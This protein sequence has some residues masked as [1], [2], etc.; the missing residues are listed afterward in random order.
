MSTATITL[1]LCTLQASSPNVIA[2]RYLDQ[3]LAAN[4]ALEANDLPRAKQLFERALELRPENPTCA[5]DLA[6]VA[7]RSGDAKSSLDWLARAAQWGYCDASVALW[8][9]DLA[10]L[11]VRSRFEELVKAM[12]EH[13]AATSARVPHFL[14]PSNI[15]RW[16]MSGMSGADATI[17]SVHAP[18][19][20]RGPIYFEE[21]DLDR[22]TASSHVSLPIETPWCLARGSDGFVRVFS[23]QHGAL[24]I[25]RPSQREV[26]ME[27]ELPDEMCEL[28]SLDVAP[29]GA[30]AVFV[31]GSARRTL[32]DVGRRAVVAEL[33][34][35]PSCRWGT[36][37]W[38]EDGSS[39]AC[40]DLHDTVH[41]Y[42]NATGVEACPP[43]T[44]REICS[45]A[46]DREAKHIAVG[47]IGGQAFVFDTATGAKVS[48]LQI[49][50]VF[51]DGDPVHSIEFSSDCTKVVAAVTGAGSIGCW[52]VERGTM[53]WQAEPTGGTE[54]RFVAHF[55]P[56][57]TR[58]LAAGMAMP[59][60]RVLDASDGRTLVD[61]SEAQLIA[62][63]STPDARFAFGGSSG[64][65]R[66]HGT[67]NFERRATFVA[68]EPSEWLYF[69]D[70]LY[71][72]GT[73]DA[74]ARELV[75]SN[76]SL[77]SVSRYAAQ[78]VDPKRV[79]ASIAGVHVRTARLA[80][81][82]KLSLIGNS[83]VHVAASARTVDLDVEVADALGFA[84]CEAEL[85]GRTLDRELSKVFV[86]LDAAPSA[87]RVHLAIARI[88]GTRVT[89]LRIVVVNRAGVESSPLNLQILADG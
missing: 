78:L 68:C 71:V 47:A 79:R 28:S 29:N 16:P 81:E 54:S 4:D 41:L 72:T 38:S 2:D 86:D 87:K 88:P 39:L 59:F 52:D 73:R 26:E 6:C 51:H 18:D 64:A 89:E 49:A 12:R 1:A 40:V 21:L 53:L 77:T 74:L 36:D 11:R 75:S 43:I 13:P 45:I 23:V 19:P 3:F 33:A 85:D 65:L 9:P 48:D 30:F 7:A 35:R 62:L 5:Y 37:A 42:R 8:D 66:I 63:D 27:I 56:T 22:A 70:S 69:T 31:H 58:V 25:Q 82:P 84:S 57:G 44:V 61:L 14:S 34:R 55:D 24:C 50:V 17:V 10:S 46:V 76:T 32:F 60:A 67:A 15:G 80:D 83:I 20:W